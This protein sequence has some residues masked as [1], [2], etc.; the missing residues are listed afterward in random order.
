MKINDYSYDRLF[1]TLCQQL[2]NECVTLLGKADRIII[3]SNIYLFYF[4]KG[5]FVFSIDSS[6]S[7]CGADEPKLYSRLNCVLR[8]GSWRYDLFASHNITHSKKYTYEYIWN[9]R[10]AWLLTKLPTSVLKFLSI[11]R[12]VPAYALSIVTIA[13]GKLMSLLGLR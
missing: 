9:I 10:Y 12:A 2:V 5:D 6:K 4:Q 7:Y 8:N 11:T 1:M 13:Y 3:D